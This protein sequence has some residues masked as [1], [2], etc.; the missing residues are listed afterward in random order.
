LI[1]DKCGDFF[2]PYRSRRNAPTAA[3]AR[4]RPAKSFTAS[5]NPWDTCKSTS[6]T[7]TSWNNAQE[8]IYPLVHIKDRECFRRS[9]KNAG[10]KRGLYPD[11]SYYNVWHS[12]S[13]HT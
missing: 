2:F 6:G 8:R 12:D 11:S 5:L 4:D 10:K 13:G 7:V 3:S 9:V 1:R